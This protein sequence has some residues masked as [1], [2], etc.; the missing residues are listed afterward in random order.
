MQAEP[1]SGLAVRALQA[2]HLKFDPSPGNF[3]A[4]KVLNCNRKTDRGERRVLS[5]PPDMYWVGSEV[6]KRTRL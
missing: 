3:S 6:V 4:S 5:F 1:H 2:L